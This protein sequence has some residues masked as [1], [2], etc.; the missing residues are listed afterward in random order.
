RVDQFIKRAEGVFSDA[1]T[2]WSRESCLNGHA[3]RHNHE[4]GC[5]G[6]NLIRLENGQ[7]REIVSQ[8]E[9]NVTHQGK[10]QSQNDADF[11][12][13]VHPNRSPELGGGMAHLRNLGETSRKSLRPPFRQIAQ[14][15][16]N[17][18]RNYANRNGAKDY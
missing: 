7:S 2:A 8:H 10:K 13:A 17:T 11:F 9:T 1:Y 16:P 4:M 14:E 18:C 12:A 3:D 15:N 6:R 5:Q